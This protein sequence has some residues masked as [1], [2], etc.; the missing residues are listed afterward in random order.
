MQALVLASLGLYYYCFN[1]GQG[2]QDSLSFD[3]SMCYSTWT[4][5]GIGVH[6]PFNSDH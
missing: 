3:N 2:S 4:G 5:P 6:L 1:V